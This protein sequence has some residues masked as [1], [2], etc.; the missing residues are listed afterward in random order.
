MGCIKLKFAAGSQVMNIIRKRA[1]VGRGST[2]FVSKI[3]AKRRVRPSHVKHAGAFMVK[4]EKHGA[5]NTI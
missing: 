1:V 2:T 5:V 4:K 3:W